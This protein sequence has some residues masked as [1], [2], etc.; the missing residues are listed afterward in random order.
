MI[1]SLD[2]KTAL[3]TGGGVGI[4]AGIASALA[5]AGARVAVTYRTHQPD[6]QLLAKLAH[7]SGKPPLA[8]ELDATLETN[9]KAVAAEIQKQFGTLDILVNNV[10]GLVARA[11]IS[12]MPFELWKDVLSVNLDSTFLV[13]HHLLP[14]LARGNGRIINI[15]SLAGRNGGHPGATAYATTKAGLFGFTRGLSKELA[16]EGITVNALAPGFIEATP[17]HDTFTSAESKTATITTIPVGRA[18]NPDDV[19]NAAIWLASDASAFVTGTVI[20]IN[21]GQYFG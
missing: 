6:E 12:D 9:V 17:F 11:K 2:G 21:G 1:R 5:A 18:G 8:I 14:I 3:V 20:D 10:G 13:T 19:A 16:P 15:A 4:G 7:I